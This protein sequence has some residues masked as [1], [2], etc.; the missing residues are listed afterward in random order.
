MGGYGL[1]SRE[2]VY[3]E[4]AGWSAHDANPARASPAAAPPGLTTPTHHALVVRESHARKTLMSMPMTV[5][6]V[7]VSTVPRCLAE[8]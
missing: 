3:P 2:C 4:R 8:R 1:V 5:G 7:R 6:R